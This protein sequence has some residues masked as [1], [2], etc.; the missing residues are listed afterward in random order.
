[1]SNTP[2]SALHYVHWW[3]QLR[4]M[5]GIMVVKIFFTTLSA[6]SFNFN[7]VIICKIVF[8]IYVLKIFMSPYMSWQNY[9]FVKSVIC[10]TTISSLDVFPKLLLFHTCLCL[11]FTVSACTASAH[12]TKLCTSWNQHDRYHCMHTMQKAV[13][14]GMPTG[15][16]L[17]CII[18]C[19]E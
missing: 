16:A 17:S 7:R 9:V 12:V 1:M 14:N 3:R 13:F 4:A 8:K 18:N 5:Y 2:I 15:F 6:D 11:W 10:R 19:S